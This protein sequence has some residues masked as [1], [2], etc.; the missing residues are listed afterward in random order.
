MLKQ[1]RRHKLEDITQAFFVMATRDPLMTG[2][3]LVNPLVASNEEEKELLKAGELR[4]NFRI[5][6]RFKSFLKRMPDFKEQTLLHSIFL[7]TV[8]KGDISLSKA[9][10]PEN[11]QWMRENS[12]NTL[13]TVFQAHPENRN[14][15]QKVFG[16]FIMRQA[17]EL[18]WNLGIMFSNSRPRVKRIC[19]IK[20]IKPIEVN[21]IVHMTAQIAYTHKNFAVIRAYAEVMYKYKVRIMTNEFYY[22]YIFQKDMPEVIPESYQSAIV[23]LKGKRRF[24][25]FIL[26][27]KRLNRK[28][29]FEFSTS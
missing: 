5:R 3:G 18:S 7:R 4:Q 25:K 6:Q 27:C 17:Y 8:P 9:I 11:C 29:C 19:D 22:I 15:Y 10:L 1:L 20:F 21:S 24:D 13:S 14:M 16:G 12:P 28:K 2:P 26:D 23:Y